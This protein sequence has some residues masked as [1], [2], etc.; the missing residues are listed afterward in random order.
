MHPLFPLEDEYAF[1]SKD[2]AEKIAKA[3][4]TNISAAAA[5]E[6]GLINNPEF[7]AS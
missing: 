1:F 6:H 7:H 2:V 3:K 4:N 5:K